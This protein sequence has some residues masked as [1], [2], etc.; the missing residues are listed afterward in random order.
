MTEEAA[1]LMDTARLWVVR[2]SEPTFTLWDDLADWLEIDPAHLAAYEAAVE[3]EAWA[4]ELLAHPEA[5]TIF[6]EDEAPVRHSHRRW[7]AGGGALA[8]SVAA[9]VA[10]LTLQPFGARLVEIE[11]APGEH[12]IVTLADGSSVILNGDTR[13]SYDAREGREM[14]LAHGEALFKIRH[15]AS[16]P[17]VVTVGDTRLVDAGTVFNVVSDDDALQ[18]GVAEGAVIYHGMDKPVQL[19]PGDVLTRNGARGPVRL[20][21]ADPQAVGS[22]NEGVLHFDNATLAEVAE[23]L[24]RACG[25]PVR[26]GAGV[27]GLRYTGTLAVD[28]P[29]ETV[30]A[31]A[32]PLLGVAIRDDGSHW[33]MTLRNAPPR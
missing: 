5:P 13:V 23:H 10:L 1:D 18:V 29:V 21:K 22:W 9:A 27:G 2:A 31:R 7:W 14:T 11:T 26:A 32:A 20:T 17:F 16:D 19:H 15:D 8:A 33:E 12:R 30:M 4:G 25:Q 6:R 3:E 24:A 28:G